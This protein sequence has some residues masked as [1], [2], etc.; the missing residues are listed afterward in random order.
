MNKKQKEFEKSIDKM[1]KT[2]IDKQIKEVLKA[3]N[4][5]DKEYNEAMEEMHDMEIKALR[6][7]TFKAILPGNIFDYKYT[8]T[9]SR[10]NDKTQQ[11]ESSEDFNDGFWRGWNDYRKEITDKI[12]ELYNIKL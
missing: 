11:W 5:E 7:E 4:D 8:P 9:L 3:F 12:L 1:I 2:D 6:E 10:F